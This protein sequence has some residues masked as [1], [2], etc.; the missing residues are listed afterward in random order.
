MF[1]TYVNIIEELQFEYPQMA[2][3]IAADRLTA[4]FPNDWKNRGEGTQPLPGQPG[5]R[6]SPVDWYGKERPVTMAT[7]LP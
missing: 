1:K 4:W 2:D 6:L 5:L 3:M 7:R